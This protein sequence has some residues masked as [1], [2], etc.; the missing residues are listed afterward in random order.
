MTIKDDF[1]QDFS[2]DPMLPLNGGYCL[3]SACGRYF[4]GVSGFD[5]HRRGPFTSLGKK[6]YCVD[7]STVGMHLNNRG[8]WVGMARFTAA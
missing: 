8:Y 3:C 7:P 2:S 4:G 1:G 6:R 5:K